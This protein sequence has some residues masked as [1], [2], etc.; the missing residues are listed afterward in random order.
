MRSLLT[1]VLYLYTFSAQAGAESVRIE[2][3]HLLVTLSTLGAELQNIQSK[4]S[5]KEY[6]WQGDPAYWNRRAPLMFPVNV[7]FRNDHYT[8][9]GKRYEMPKLGLVHQRELEVSSRSRSS[10]TMTLTSN[11]DTL[12]YYPFNFRFSIRY[13][14]IDTELLH[15]FTIENLGARTMYYA[16]GGHPGFAFSSDGAKTR[17]D[18]RLTLPQPTTIDRVTLSEGLIQP[19]T[20]P[21]LNNEDHLAMDDPR[22]PKSGMLLL[23]SGVPQFGIARK[24]KSAFLTVNLGSF[25]NVNIW[26]PPGMPYVAIEPQ[27]GHHDLANSPIA[28]EDKNYLTEQAGNSTAKYHFSIQV[29]DANEQE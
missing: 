29:H 22:I 7:K 13:S 12:R 9:D 10:V 21:F 19:Y 20:I 27:L 6:L 5:G 16:L 2:N 25:P 11:E 15:E 23:A 26:S 4:Q 24:G 14:L 1:L 17:A 18:Y 3:V 28:I 8:F